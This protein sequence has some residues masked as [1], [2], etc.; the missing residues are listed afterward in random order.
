MIGGLIFKFKESIK[1]RL[2][3]IKVKLIRFVLIANG[4]RL[5]RYFIRR[6]IVI[7]YPLVLAA[8][9]L[10]GFSLSKIHKSFGNGRSV[11]RAIGGSLVLF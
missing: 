2:S 6:F 5:L 11:W 8:C 1:Q 9:Q 10:L 4:I 7:W 3:V